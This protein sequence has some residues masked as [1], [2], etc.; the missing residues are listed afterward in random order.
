M[1]VIAS[2]A[3]FYRD[4]VSPL[5]GVKGFG[6][7][8]ANDWLPAGALSMGINLV[9]NVLIALLL[10]VVNR[11]YNLLRSMTVLFST[12]F[13]VMEGAIPG[14][15]NQLY[16]G[17]VLCLVVLMA[18]AMLFS[19]FNLRR[20]EKTVFLIF[21]ILGLCSLSQY[22]YLTFFPIFLLGCVQ[23]RI[24]SFK[25]FVA[26]CLGVVAPTW[27]LWAL[28]VIDF[29]QMTLPRFSSIFSV[30]DMHEALH[31][32]VTVGVTAFIILILGVLNFMKLYS[33]NSRTR[34]YN[35]FI[36]LL[37]VWTMLMMVVDYT[38]L[39]T[40]WPLLALCAAIQVGHFFS[41]HRSRRSYIGIL[42]LF[43]A[44][45]SLYAWA[46]IIS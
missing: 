15:I 8:T 26:A 45:A 5:D 38:N 14:L 12:A 1:V 32:L 25:A 28:G 13:L 6:L 17:T 7:P 33:Y 29:A 9:A 2:L 30:I 39:I 31:L 42:V 34:A 10:V 37:T 23:M 4:G 21:F 11:R 44:Y 35:G 46:V 27:I 18:T 22:A 41:I 20:D 40:Y 24:F 43:A 19:T 36:G 16:S 3:A